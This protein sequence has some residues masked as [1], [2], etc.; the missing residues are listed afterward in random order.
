[1]PI[2]TLQFMTFYKNMDTAENGEVW[3]Y[4]W[5]LFVCLCYQRAN[6]RTRYGDFFIRYPK[7][8]CLLSPKDSNNRKKC[9]DTCRVLLIRTRIVTCY[10]ITRMALSS[11]NLTNGFTAFTNSGLLSFFCTSK[12]SQLLI[13]TSGHY[14]LAQVFLLHAPGLVL[15]RISSFSKSWL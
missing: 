9:T 12:G 14:V 4:Y 8:P 15:T 13:I 7:R 1:M 2:L 10:Q 11:F 6:M 3:A 5:L